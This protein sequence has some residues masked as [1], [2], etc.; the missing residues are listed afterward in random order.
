MFRE[1]VSSAVDR[2]IPWDAGPSQG[3]EVAKAADRDDAGT[4][5]LSQPPPGLPAMNTVSRF[6][7]IMALA[8]I[9][10]AFLVSHRNCCM[11]R[12]RHFPGLA[13]RRTP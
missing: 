4:A 11:Q 9:G 8:A 10:I 7:Q 5:N 2:S 1:P 12:V 6:F 13:G 3:P